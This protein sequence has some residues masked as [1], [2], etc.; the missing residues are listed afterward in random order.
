MRI[1]FLFFKSEHSQVHMSACYF[2]LFFQFWSQ[3]LFANGEFW[4]RNLLFIYKNELHVY[5]FALPFKEKSTLECV[6]L[7]SCKMHVAVSF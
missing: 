1:Y 3:D 5:V 4:K 7:L 2:I 6:Q